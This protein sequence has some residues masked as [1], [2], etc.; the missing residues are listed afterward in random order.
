[1][2]NRILIGIQARSTS[3]RLPGKALK[4]L[5]NK[6]I[7]SWVLN[8]C[9][10]SRVY[11]ERTNSDMFIQTAILCPE[12]DPIKPHYFDYDVIEGDEFDVLSR[13]VKA[14][15]LYKSDYVV[16]ITGDCPFLTGFMITNLILKAVH[17]KFDYVSNVDPACRTELDGRDIEVISYEALNWLDREALSVEDREHVTTKLRAEKPDYL[18]RGHVLNRLDVSDIKLSIDTQQDFENCEKRISEFLRKKQIAENDVGSGNVF[19]M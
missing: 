2:I 17:G 16:R 15:G 4:K 19:Y 8:A 13:F 6:P 11:L 10:D 9:E 14:C 1:M 3:A 5:Y 12:G 18:K 7:L